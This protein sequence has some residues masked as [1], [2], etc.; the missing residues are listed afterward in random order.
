[1]VPLTSHDVHT[2]LRALRTLYAPCDLDAFPAQLHAALQ[3]VVA[4][5]SISFNEINPR[6]QRVRAVAHPPEATLPESAAIL[7]R[8]LHEHPLISRYQQTRDGRAYKISDFLTPLHFHRLGLYNELY[9]PLGMEDQMALALPTPPPLVLGI[10]LNR[11]RRSFS[12]RDRRLLNL[13]RPHLTQAYSNAELRTQM[14]QELRRLRQ[15]LEALERGLILLDRRGRVR[16]MTARARQ[17]LPRYFGRYSQPASR[18]PPAL[19]QWIRQQQAQLRHDDVVPPPLAPL[20][21]QGEGARLL[22]RCLP[23]PSAEEILLLLDEQPTEV[24]AASLERLGLSR[25]EAEVLGWVMQGKTNPEVAIILGISAR[26]VQKHLERIY[27]KLGVETR[28]AAAA[29]ALGVLDLRRHWK[30]PGGKAP[31]Y[32]H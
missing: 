3:Q 26:T 6:R 12:A 7:A 13:L 4:A 10:A 24:A 25:R 14:R 23:G 15:A 21:V 20:V 9:R 2:L 32:D 17:W 5:E 16:L 30:Y 28:T 8:H 1:M 18:L 22:V 31:T 19:R 29:R 27:Q 11:R